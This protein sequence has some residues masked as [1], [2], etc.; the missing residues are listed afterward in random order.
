M[1]RLTAVVATGTVLAVAGCA[2]VPPERRDAGVA[3]FQWTWSAIAEECHLLSFI[4]NHDT[5]R[6]GQ[7]LSYRD[8]GGF[9]AATAVMLATDYGPP[10]LYSGYAFSDR[11]A[12]PVLES[13]GSVADASCTEDE[14]P[15]VVAEAGWA[16]GAW[17][18]QHR[19]P[20]TLELVAWR[21][22]V[23]DAPV[24]ETGSIESVH[25][26]LR[27]ES[28]AFAMQLDD[29]AASVEAPVGL[30]DG[31]YCDVVVPDC[32]SVVEVSGGVAALE[33]GPWQAVALDRF[34]RP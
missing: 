16:D 2:S 7:T 5:E 18:C 26:S 10:T 23:V 20:G 19:W 29:E 4:A 24:T 30:P 31:T 25:T 27:G 14:H 33:L 8:G 15:D 11:D 1:R 28:A 6:N 12:G 22:R 17:V 34:T 13:D 3:M 9:A 21:T 32:A